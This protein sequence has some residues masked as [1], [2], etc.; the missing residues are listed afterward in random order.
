[1]E[2][3]LIAKYGIDFV[4]YANLWELERI[5]TAKELVVAREIRHRR[6]AQIGKKENK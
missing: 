1:M 2:T 6:T 4:A 3:T 5:M